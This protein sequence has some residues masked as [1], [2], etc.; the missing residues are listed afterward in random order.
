[1]LDPQLLDDFIA[2]L[3]QATD[4][5]SEGRVDDGYQ[6]LLAALERARHES[7]PQQVR[8]WEM[9]VARYSTSFGVALESE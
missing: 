9:A 7:P 1:M 2:T 3:R 6:Y 4:L 8:L 5:A